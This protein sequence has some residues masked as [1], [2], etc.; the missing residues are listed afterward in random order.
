MELTFASIMEVVVTPITVLIGLLGNG[1]SILVLSKKEIQLRSSFTRILIALSVFDITFIS[2]SAALFSIRAMSDYYA[3]EIYPWTVPILLPVA[4]ISLTASVYTT[5]V[6]CFDRYIAI[7]RPALLG[8]GG[9]SEDTTSWGLIIGTV[10]FSVIYNFSRFFEFRV[11]SL[12]E[13]WM[14]SNV[15]GQFLYMDPK[16]QLG[17][18]LI[19]STSGDVFFVNKTFLVVEQTELRSNIEYIQYYILLTNFIFMGIIPSIIMIIFNVLVVRAVNEANQRRARMTRR[20]Q[21]NITVTSMLVTVVVV[22]LVCHSVKLIINGYEVYE[23]VK[24]NVDMSPA[25]AEFNENLPNN[26]FVPPIRVSMNET[27]PHL[28]IRP[29][30]AEVKMKEQPTEEP[31]VENSS[32]PLW[33][34]YMT[35]VSHWLLILNSSCNIAIYLH[36]DPKF[37]AVLKEMVLSKLS[38]TLRNKIELS[39]GGQDDVELNETQN[40]IGRKKYK[41]D[42]VSQGLSTWQAPS[43]H[44]CTSTLED[45]NGSQNGSCQGPNLL[46][47]PKST[48]LMTSVYEEE[49]INEP[50][51]TNKE[52]EIAIV[53]V[54]HN[55]K[56]T[57][58]LCHELLLPTSN[59]SKNQNHNA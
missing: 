2:A 52:T 51:K 28:S 18:D 54:E 7:C 59:G 42:S 29:H 30:M 9:R 49:V 36:K 25:E 32:W 50:I 35:V 46:Q 27:T 40:G 44:D 34:D 43:P 17:L 53:E 56:G 3:E 20:Q 5:V 55:N 31:N 45:R 15:T 57:D 47:I 39:L 21:R 13:E 33:V 38:P 26:N 4:Q 8:C 14:F 1:L 37:K 16:S 11:Q 23:M 19:N 48:S 41:S 22:F 24:S 6:T 10:F 58:E 12:T